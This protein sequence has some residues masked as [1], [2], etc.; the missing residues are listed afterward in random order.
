MRSSWPAEL[1]NRALALLPSAA[2]A[3][4]EGAWLAVVYAAVQAGMA[5]RPLAT[6]VWAFVLAAALGVVFAHRTGGRRRTVLTAASCAA[7]GLVGWAMDPQVRALAASGTLAAAAMTHPA[8]WLLGVATWRGSRHADP[9]TDDL[10]VGSLLFWGVPGLAVPW[11][12]GSTIGA[13]AAFIDA[14]LPA[15]LLFMG[16]GLVAVGLT[17][18]DALGR[19]VGVDWRKNRTWVALLVGVVALVVAIGTPAAVLL[20]ASVDAMINTVIGPIAALVGG[21]GD[22][23]IALLGAVGALAGSAAPAGASPPP[24]LPPGPAMPFSAPAGLSNAFAVGVFLLLIVAVILVWRRVRGA[25]R[26]VRWQPPRSEERRIALPRPSVRI[27]LPHLPRLSFPRS[28]R[29]RTA[30][31]AYLAVLAAFDRNERIARR[32]GE[33]PAAHARR[34]RRQGDGSLPLDLLAADFALA[35]YGGAKLT[36]AET[37]RAIRRWRTGTALRRGGDDITDRP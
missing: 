12:V 24:S 23:V 14:A 4:A 22:L 32:V 34:L 8:G 25:P 31:E 16:A 6:E 3:A 1:G 2:T 7:I 21:A 27:T 37:A 11:L 26:T 30:I 5:G 36:R 10:V 29:P 9:T 28:I 20:G 17:R 35:R 19:D 33:S 18:L 15:T 13:R